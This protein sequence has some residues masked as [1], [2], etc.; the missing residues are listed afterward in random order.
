MY[1]FAIHHYA[2]SLLS[3]L[4]PWDPHIHF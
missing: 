2:V 3:Y 1:T 4:W